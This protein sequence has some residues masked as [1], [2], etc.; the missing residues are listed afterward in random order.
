MYKGHPW[1]GEVYGP[2]EFEWYMFTNYII[3][4]EFDV[5]YEPFIRF[6]KK[7]GKNAHEMVMKVASRLSEKHL[8]QFVVAKNRKM[9]PARYPAGYVRKITPDRDMLE[10]VAV[11]EKEGYFSERLPRDR[12]N[13]FAYYIVAQFPRFAFWLARTFF[14]YRETKDRFALLVTRN[15][16]RNLGRPIVFHGT[17]YPCHFLLIPFGSKVRTLFGWPHVYGNVDRMEGFVKDWI[18]AVERPESIPRE[19][20]DKP[21][22][23]LAPKTTEQ[24]EQIRRAGPWR[25]RWKKNRTTS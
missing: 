4:V 19:L 20:V 2:I 15:P 3:N 5:D 11:R 8:D 25:A 1:E 12:V 22:E 24:A 21:Y 10:W 23:R 7:E 6:C 17:G 18:E 14:A 13:D 9:Y 16:M